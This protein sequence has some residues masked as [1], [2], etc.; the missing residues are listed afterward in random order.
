[1]ADHTPGRSARAVIADT[2]V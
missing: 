1:M 2:S